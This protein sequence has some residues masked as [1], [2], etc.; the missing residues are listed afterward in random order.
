MRSYLSSRRSKDGIEVIAAVDYDEALFADA[1]RQRSAPISAELQPSSELPQPQPVKVAPQREPRRRGRTCPR[2]KSRRLRKSR[3]AKVARK[4]APA[5]KVIPAVKAAPAT[6][7]RAAPQAIPASRT[8]ASGNSGLGDMQRELKDL[9]RML[10]SGL[11][12]LAGT[13]RSDKRLREPLQA[14]VLEELSAMDIAPDVAM[15]LAAL[16]PLHTNLKDPSHISWR[17]W[18]NICRWSTT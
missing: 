4:V 5:V 1:N 15:A 12:G 2:R 10:E 14:R 8:A 6:A 18:S 13:T 7:A 11:A 3:L 17:C 9:R 16:A